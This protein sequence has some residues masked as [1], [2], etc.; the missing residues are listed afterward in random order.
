MNQWTPIVVNGREYVRV[1]AA[2]LET[3][4]I[5]VDGDTLID[6]SIGEYSGRV[7]LEWESG[8]VQYLRHNST[9]LIGYDSSRF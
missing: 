7:K 9:L 6:L 2:E 1:M 3:G 5:N 8:Y 4:D